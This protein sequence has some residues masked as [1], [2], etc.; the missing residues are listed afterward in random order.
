MSKKMLIIG[1]VVVLLIFGVLGGGFY[2]ILN[3][4]T[5]LEHQIQAASGGEGAHNAQPQAQKKHEETETFSLDSLIVNLADGD[6]SRYLRINMV[7]EIAK[8]EAVEEVEKRKP[9]LKN[10]ALMLLPTKSF[11]Q[12]NSSE[13]KTAL[14][15]ELMKKMNEVLGGPIISDIFFTEFVIQ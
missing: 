9:H 14:R 12:L 7:L 13:G 10:I 1:L 8:K 3:K 15:D 5:T 2:M 6:G 4:I 11:Q